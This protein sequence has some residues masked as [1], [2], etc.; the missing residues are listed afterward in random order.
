MNFTRRWSQNS[1]INDTVTQLTADYKFP[2]RVQLIEQSGYQDPFLLQAWW[3]MYASSFGIGDK[4]NNHAPT[5]YND[6]AHT[7]NA[8]YSESGFRLTPR[9]M[10]ET[11]L[12]DAEDVGKVLAGNRQEYA[13]AATL[14]FI[15]VMHDLLA[16]QSGIDFRTR[17]PLLTN[18]GGMLSHPAEKYFQAQFKPGEK[19]VVR[20]EDLLTKLDGLYAQFHITRKRI[21]GFYNH[22]IE[23]WRN[24]DGLVDTPEHSYLPREEREYIR[25]TING[26]I[27]ATL[28]RKSHGRI[29]TP[30]DINEVMRREFELTRHPIAANGL[31]KFPEN[32]RLPHQAQTLLDLRMTNYD[33]YI[34]GIF[35]YVDGEA[36]RAL[37]NGTAQSADSYLSLGIEKAVDARDV[38][39]RPGALKLE[40]KIS[41]GLKDRTILN[42]GTSQVTVLRDDIG[43]PY[44]RIW[45]ALNFLYKGL[46]E[47]SERGLRGLEKGEDINTTPHKQELKKLREVHRLIKAPP[48]LPP[49]QS[50]GLGYIF[51]LAKGTVGL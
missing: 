26:F 23:R 43:V 12:H 50:K 14:V 24:V 31:I 1:G 25:D 15:D 39:T 28:A 21:G 5:H 8:R 41:I 10:A 13:L 11:L 49:T 45:L 40:E 37:A 19:F 36:R 38:V 18:S 51:S 30:E 22:L 33:R 4:A 17:I 46:V 44:E 16:E 32:L 35:R 34:E 2:T 3:L 7:A 47:T 48:A 42:K 6:A 29:L 9:E 27:G 20:R